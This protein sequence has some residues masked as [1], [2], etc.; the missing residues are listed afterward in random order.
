[1]DPGHDKIK[2]LFNLTSDPTERHD[3]SKSMPEKVKE[4]M[5]R[6]EEYRETMIEPDVAKEVERGSPMNFGGFYSPGWCQAE[7]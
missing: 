3:L 7:P 6:L 4:L 1:M 2:L 5:A